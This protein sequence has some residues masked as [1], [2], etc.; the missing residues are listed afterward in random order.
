MDN[1]TLQI[2]LDI[3][4]KVSATQEAVQALAGP[5]G[6][7][8]KLEHAQDTINTRQWIKATVVAPVIIGLQI[9]LKHY[10]IGK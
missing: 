8:T 7:V 9:V 3:Q 5:E 10:G 1:T 4:G 2:L 6:R